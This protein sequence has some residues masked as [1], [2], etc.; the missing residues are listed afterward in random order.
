MK[1]HLL[2]DSRVQAGA[3]HHSRFYSGWGEPLRMFFDKE[4]EILNFSVGGRSS[5]SYINEGRFTDNGLFTKDM[6]PQ[7]MGPALPQISEGDYVLIQ[8][9]YNDDDS[10]GCSYRV[11][12]HVWLGDPDENGIYPTVVPTDEMRRPTEE[13]S[14][15]YEEALAAE[16][17]DDDKIKTIMETTEELMGLVGDTYHPFDSGATYKGYLKFYIDKIREKGA[18]PI[19]VISGV[20]YFFTDGIIAPVP[21]FGGGR[22]DYNDFPYPEAIRQLGKEENVP[23]ID[24]F[25]AEK[26]LYEALGEEKALYLHNI[27]VV[28]GDVR[29][30]DRAV[31]TDAKNDMDNWLEEYNTRMETKDYSAKDLVHKNRF[32]AFFEAAEVVDAMYAQGILTEHILKIP[33]GFPGLPAGLEGDEKLLESHLKHIKP[34]DM[35]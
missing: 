3:S 20:A 22:D 35:R 24:L 28:Q 6:V 25:S 18:N 33:S 4:T 2:G 14:N 7:G 29:N 34:F 11:N 5:R 26:S 13:W 1:V 10:I 9:M 19:L 23:V 21:G 15:G 30:I 32:G 31:S 17:Y 8:F 12:K 16:G 27:S